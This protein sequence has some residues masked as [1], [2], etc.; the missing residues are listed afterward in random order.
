MDFLGHFYAFSRYLTVERR[1]SP[2]HQ[3]IISINFQAEM[4]NIWTSWSVIFKSNCKNLKPD[5]IMNRHYFLFLCLYWVCA[6]YSKQFWMG[7]NFKQ[8]WIPVQIAVSHQS[9]KSR[10]FVFKRSETMQTIC[11]SININ[12]ARHG[13]IQ[14]WFTTSVQYWASGHRDWEE[15][16]LLEFIWIAHEEILIFIT[17]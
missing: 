8:K 14:E 4:P 1:W 16:G 5:Q 12:K 3:L 6:A 17:N 11:S 13:L 15:N 2:N 7:S 10:R 9:S